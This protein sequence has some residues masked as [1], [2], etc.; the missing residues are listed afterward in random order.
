[1]AVRAIINETSKANAQFALVSNASAVV[2]IVGNL[3]TVGADLVVLTKNQ[4]MMCYKIAAAHDRE[5]GNQFAIIRELSPVVGAGFIWRTIA[6]EASAMIPLA[7]G[8]IPKVAV[9]YAG[10]TAI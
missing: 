6:R 8:T 4:V 10:T 2:P 7:A 1:D 3:M 5:L 9:A